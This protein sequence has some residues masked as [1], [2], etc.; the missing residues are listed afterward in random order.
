MTIIK[1]KTKNKFKKKMTSESQPIPTVDIEDSTAYVKQMLNSIT[2]KDCMVRTC[3]PL[4]FHSVDLTDSGQYSKRCLVNADCVMDRS[5]DYAT[6]DIMDRM[7]ES[8]Q[9]PPGTDIL[10]SD[11]AQDVRSKLQSQLFTNTN[12]VKV[13]QPIHVMYKA[14]GQIDT[15]RFGNEETTFFVNKLAETVVSTP[16]KPEKSVLEKYALPILLFGVIGYSV[17]VY[18]SKK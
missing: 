6:T 16:S 4:Q 15:S 1:T 9:V 12:P 11:N 13:S 18:N 17:Y 3:E 8:K 7:S 10:I 2:N 5:L 14:D